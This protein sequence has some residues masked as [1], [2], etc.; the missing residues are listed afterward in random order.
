MLV[1]SRYESEVVVLVLPDGR[2]IR[3]AITGFGRGAHGRLKARVGIE[4]PRDVRIWR[5]ELV[6]QVREREAGGS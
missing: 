5:Q 2:E 3:V 6:A 4:A 1:V